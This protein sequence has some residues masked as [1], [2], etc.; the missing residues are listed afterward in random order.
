M[1]SKQRTVIAFMVS[2]LQNR[3]LGAGCCG[4][5]FFVCMAL[6][7]DNV[8]L[9]SIF[10]VLGAQNVKPVVTFGVLGAQNV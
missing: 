6:G 3:L 2:G 8:E 9:L 10:R 7:Y 4:M 1:L 5:F